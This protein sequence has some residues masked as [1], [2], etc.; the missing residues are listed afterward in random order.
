MKV[1]NFFYE[2]HHTMEVLTVE[3]LTLLSNQLQNGR[4]VDTP[5]KRSEFQPL[6]F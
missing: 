2:S 1:L 5:T 4:T 3:V 6:T